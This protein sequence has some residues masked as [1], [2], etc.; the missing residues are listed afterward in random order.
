M[1]TRFSGT[2]ELFQKEG[3]GSVRTFLGDDGHAWF[4]ATDICKTLGVKNTPQA[5]T[6][7][8]DAEKST[9]IS[10][11]S[12]QNGKKVV[13]KLTIVSESGLYMLIMSSRKKEAVDFQRWVTNE[14]LPS[15]RKNGGYIFGQE[16]LAPKDKVLTE[17]LI[18]AL[19]EKVQKLKKRR[20]ELLEENKELK[21]EKRKDKKNLKEYDWI[22]ST[23]EGMIDAYYS[24]FQK[25]VSENKSLKRRL[26]LI[27]NPTPQ[28]IAK[29]VE[30]EYFYDVEGNRYSTHEEALEAIEARRG[31]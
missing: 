4:V 10:N 16:Q 11:D 2:F 7:L 27:K 14:V 20:H 8:N 13:H 26:E 15:I 9:I 3:L 23:Y 18:H 28:S 17:G 29:K 30:P 12:G 6:R 22:C 25:V 31:N 5:L 1:K 19:S 24:D 21:S